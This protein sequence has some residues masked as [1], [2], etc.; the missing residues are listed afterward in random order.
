[1]TAPGIVIR[2]AAARDG[3]ALARLAALDSAAPPMGPL[4]VAE[5]EGE[6][7]AALAVGDGDTIA[8]PF[9]RTAELVDLLRLRASQL[10]A[11]REASRRHGGGLGEWSRGPRSVATD[12]A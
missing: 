6:I 7:R 3:G 9:H 2:R 11:P 1:V 5:V 12:T 10:E 8:D 4:L